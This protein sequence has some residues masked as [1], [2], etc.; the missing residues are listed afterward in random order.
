[1][2]HLICT[3]FNRHFNWLQCNAIGVQQWQA[4][5]PHDL[6]CLFRLTVKKRLTLLGHDQNNFPSS[7]R[8]LRKSLHGIEDR[9]GRP[10]RTHLCNRLDV[11]FCDPSSPWQRGTNG[12]TDGLLWQCCLDSVASKLK[13]CQ[14][15]TLKCHTPHHM[16]NI[17][18]RWLDES[19]DAK[20]GG[21]TKT[22]RVYLKKKIL[23][24]RWNVF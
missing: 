16:L 1:M 8:H 18:L 12:K 4:N 11:Y 2:G 22:I 23:Q 3:P 20:N 24:W 21:I 14:R 9:A 19:I 10:C 5:D 6:P 15:R 17:V 13:D 7:Q